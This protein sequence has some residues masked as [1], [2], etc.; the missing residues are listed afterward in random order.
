MS[1]HPGIDQTETCLASVHL[2]PST[3]ILDLK[4]MYLTLYLII[5]IIRNVRIWHFVSFLFLYVHIMNIFMQ[6]IFGQFYPI[7]TTFLLYAVFAS[8]LQHI[9]VSSFFIHF[10]SMQKQKQESDLM[11][12]LL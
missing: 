12:L 6:V 5:L 10:D 4:I 7:F 3:H 2:L 8:G 1:P 11:S 9:Y